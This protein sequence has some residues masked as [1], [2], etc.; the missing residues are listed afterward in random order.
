[1]SWRAVFKSTPAVWIDLGS[2][3]RQRPSR[4]RRA[5][6]PFIPHRSKSG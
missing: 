2:R 3:P 4:A 5:R 6:R 1:V